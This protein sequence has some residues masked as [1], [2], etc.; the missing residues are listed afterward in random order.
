[1]IIN[2]KNHHKTYLL[3]AV[4]SMGILITIF[5][6]ILP[7]ISQINKSSKELVENRLTTETFFANWRNLQTTQQGIEE[8]RNNLDKQQPLLARD[9]AVEFIKSLE[10][11]ASRT[12]NAQKIN[13]LKEGDRKESS[14]DFQISLQ[15]SFPN[16]MKFLIN[17]ENLSYCG[18]IKTI[19]ITNINEPSAS[20]A[21]DSAAAS[22]VNSLISLSVL[23]Y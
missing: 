7:L 22:N 16:L 10:E 1:M 23:T 3:A 15:G 14:I 13:V 6:I 19:N 21:G 9:S 20:R 17:I 8:I 2:I 11:T 5:F 18:K 12:A 4:F